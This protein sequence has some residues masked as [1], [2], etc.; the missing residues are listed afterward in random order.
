MRKPYSFMVQ[1]NGSVTV[2]DADGF[3][4]QTIR[5]T[6]DNVAAAQ[7]LIDALNAEGE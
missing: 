2:T 1:S 5:N 3:I 6:E 4:V 7:A